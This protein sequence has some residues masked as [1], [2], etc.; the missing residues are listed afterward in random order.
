MSVYAPAHMH[1]YIYKTYISLKKESKVLWYEIINTMQHDTITMN[2]GT[3]KHYKIHI[4]TQSTILLLYT[5]NE[6]TFTRL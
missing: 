5:T 2:K 6:I 4:Y 3:Q 1:I